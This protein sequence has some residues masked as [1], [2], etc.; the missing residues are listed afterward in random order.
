MGPA[1]DLIEVRLC[2][3]VC[4]CVVVCVYGVC[5]CTR[6]RMTPTHPSTH[7]PTHAPKKLRTLINCDQNA[8]GW[9]MSARCL[10]GDGPHTVMG[11]C[12]HAMVFCVR[13]GICVQCFDGVRATMVRTV[14]AYLPLSMSGGGRVMICER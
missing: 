7:P 4:V 1:S 6:A 2:V 10:S 5:V 3:C 13:D 8:A 14:S 11:W 9:L 12:V